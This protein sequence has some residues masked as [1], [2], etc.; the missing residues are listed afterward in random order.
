MNICENCE[1]KQVCYDFIE[2][3]KPHDFLENNMCKHCTLPFD[4][5][6]MT[7]LQTMLSGGKNIKITVEEK[8]KIRKYIDYKFRL[9]KP[10]TNYDKITESVESLAEYISSLARKCT[11]RDCSKEECAKFECKDCIK[12][13]LQ[14]ECEDD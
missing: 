4:G 9:E 3:G 12:E 10:I 7:F 11:F 6:I 14:K 2:Y 8:A 1:H 5:K 13:W